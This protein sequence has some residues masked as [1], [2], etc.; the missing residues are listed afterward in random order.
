MQRNVRPKFNAQKCGFNS[1]TAKPELGRTRR[2]QEHRHFGDETPSLSMSDMAAT[3][4]VCILLLCR[5]DQVHQNP[6]VPNDSD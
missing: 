6:D 2:L 5:A 3:E 4:F 1:A